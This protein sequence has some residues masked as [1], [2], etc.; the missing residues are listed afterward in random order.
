MN[1]QN[2]NGDVVKKDPISIP[3]P[4]PPQVNEIPE[5][6][7]DPEIS[8]SAKVSHQVADWAGVERLEGFKL[9]DVFSEALKKHSREEVEEYFTVGTRSTT[10]PI[11]L[12]NTN[13]PK[14]WVFLRTFIAAALIYFLFV[15]AWNEYQNENLIPGLIMMG[16]FAV[17]LS[18]L[19]FFF[20]MNALK[21]VSL[22]QVLRL[23]FVG[24]IT[25]IIISLFFFSKT[26]NTQLDS[27]GASVAGLV[28]EPGK[29]LALFLVINIPRF[30]YTL[31]GLLFGA[32]IGTGFAAFESMGYALRTGFEVGSEGMLS[33]IMV[34]GMLS[35]FSHIIWTAMCGAALW[36]VKGDKPFK[37]QM[38]TDPK[39]YRIFFMA[40]IMHM[41]WNSG[42][43][44]PLY[45]K[46]ILLGVIGWIVIFALIQSGLK[47]IRDEKTIA[48]LPSS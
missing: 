37:L 32:A 3:P 18:A 14:P 46:Y 23:L 11:S 38:L 24:G 40:V 39:F 29:L 15:G 20:E 36:R 45:S 1:D 41:I 12:I 21:N 43:K 44:L 8:F 42:L 28:E 31:N 10:P 27:L 22:Y 35:P 26:D 25:S 9:S 7:Q 48:S 13:W 34:R 6:K 30:K 17:P 16:S 33:N 4:P 5:K 19:I 2:N 47:Q